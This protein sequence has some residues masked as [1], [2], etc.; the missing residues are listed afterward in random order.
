VRASFAVFARSFV[1][2]DGKY[3][4]RERLLAM[5][6]DEPAAPNPEAGDSGAGDGRAESRSELVER[7]F[8]EHNE[9]L[10]RFLAARLQSLQEA[11]DVAQEAYVRLLNMDTITTVSHLRAFLFKTAA[12]IAIDRLR[13]RQHEARP[14]TV[15]FFDDQ[16][17]DLPPERRL[18]AT[19]ELQ[20]VATFLQELPP[21][22]RHAFLLRRLHGLSAQQI[23]E[24]MDIPLRTIR[25]YVVEA[26]VYC[27]V[28][29][30]EETQKAMNEES[31][32]KD[33]GK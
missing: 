8:R 32:A 9:A 26:L 15:E 23:S 3:F 21:R 18:A 29:L 14:T 31:P 12:N 22:C 27:R 2:V 5:A 33:A 19:Q 13:S 28:R 1:S 6:P 7:L 11:R 25:H 24:Q 10:L 4:P 17:G 20:L 30:D 16:P